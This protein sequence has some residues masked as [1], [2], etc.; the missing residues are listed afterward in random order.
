MWAAMI[1]A[2]SSAPHS[3]DREGPL[4]EIPHA[5]KAVHLMLYA[6]LGFL[7]YQAGSERWR[8]GGAG[9]VIGAVVIASLY[10]I[11]DEW[12]QA[13]V[14]GRTPSAMDWLF[15]TLGALVGVL[16]AARVSAVI[17]TLSGRSMNHCDSSDIV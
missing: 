12:H 6:V 2:L 17:G 7:V 16:M 5:D 1:F 9:W 15:D 4:A 10:G 11:G 14:P 13:R 8:N 3:K